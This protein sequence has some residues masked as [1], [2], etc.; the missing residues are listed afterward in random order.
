ML[1]RAL[2]CCWLTLAVACAGGKI[3]RRS[4]AGKTQPLENTYGT[5]GAPPRLENG[6]VNMVKLLAELEELNA[7]TYHWLIWQNENDWDDLKIFLP[8]ARKANLKVWVTVVPPTESKP[9]AKYSSEPYQTDYRKWA[10]AFARLSLEQPNL[11]AWSID[12]FAHNLKTFTPSYTDSCLQAAKAVNP[13]LLFVPCVY[14]RQ[15]TPQFAAGYGKLLDGLLFPYRA[16]SAGANLKD[17]SMVES[18]IAAIRKL[19]KPGMPVFVDIY[20]TAHSR[21]G[22]ST[23]EY[24]RQ[25]L[26]YSKRYADGVLIYCHQDPVRSAAKYNIIKEGFARR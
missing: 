21:L 5:Y 26:E 9:V 1:Q 17:P 13:R 12:D 6:R 3:D 25:V 23:P 24:V 2:I 11:T 8:L 18:E 20:A 15:I 14:Y 10:E 19:F 4:A 16:E 22:A 7:T